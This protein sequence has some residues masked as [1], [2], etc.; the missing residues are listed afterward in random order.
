MAL[1]FIDGDMLLL[2]LPSNQ[3]VCQWQDAL[4][5]FLPA[6]KPKFDFLVIAY[7]NEFVATLYRSLKRLRKTAQEVLALDKIL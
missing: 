1:I 4:S 2:W 5:G 3:A 7:H 6:E